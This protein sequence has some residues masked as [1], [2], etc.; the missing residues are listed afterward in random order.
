MIDRQF[1]DLTICEKMG[2]SSSYSY[3]WTSSKL[4][5][6]LLNSDIVPHLPLLVLLGDLLNDW[7]EV[8]TILYCQLYTRHFGGVSLP[9]PM[10]S[11]ASLVVLGVG[12]IAGMPFAYGMHGRRTLLG[13]VGQVPDCQFPLKHDFQCPSRLHSLLTAGH[14]IVILFPT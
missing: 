11:I 12:L 4:L 9:A 14:S 13:I 6:P 2:A 7:C 8:S 3:T 1:N 5:L 10:W